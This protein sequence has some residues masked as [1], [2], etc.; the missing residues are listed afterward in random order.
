MYKGSVIRLPATGGVTVQQKGDAQFLTWVGRRLVL[1]EL[2]VKCPEWNV[3]N[4]TVPAANS[5]NSR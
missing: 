4:E 3:A 5:S 1:L 2:Y